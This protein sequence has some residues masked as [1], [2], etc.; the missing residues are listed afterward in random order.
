M[1]EH[2]LTGIAM[3]DFPSMP[4]LPDLPGP[5]KTFLEKLRS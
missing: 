3:M 1:M 4:E 5:V 2:R